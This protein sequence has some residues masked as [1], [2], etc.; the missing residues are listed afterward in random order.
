[1]VVEMVNPVDLSS[2]EVPF[3]AA[4]SQQLAATTAMAQFDYDDDD[5]VS[6]QFNTPQIPTR[7]ETM[8]ARRFAVVADLMGS[9]RS[10]CTELIC[11][12]NRSIYS[13]WKDFL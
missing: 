10:K 7:S 1:V 9:A 11:W 6:F 4:G 13:I 5:D 12:A 2:E 3:D 8:T